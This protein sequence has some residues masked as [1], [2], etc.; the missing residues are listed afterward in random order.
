ME[1]YNCAERRAFPSTAPDSD[2]AWAFVRYSLRVAHAILLPTHAT[3]GPQGALDF[4]LDDAHVHGNGA[5]G[6]QL[7]YPAKRHYPV[8][9]DDSGKEPERVAWRLKER[10]RTVSV[11]L[12][13]CLNIRVDPPDVIK[14]SPCVPCPGARPRLRVLEGAD[15]GGAGR[16]ARLECWTDPYSMSA[17]KVPPPPSTLL[18]RTLPHRTDAGSGRTR[19]P[20]SARTRVLP[21]R[22]A[23]PA[24]RARAGTDA[25]APPRPW[26]G[27]GDYRQGARTAVPALAGKSR[28]GPVIPEAGP[29]S[30]AP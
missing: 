30:A 26:A 29:L 21:R 25:P 7:L 18:R 20:A 19:H 27:A 14:P 17:P 1:A 2:C 4:T 16:C 3:R 24:A 15:A 11:A 8:N 10:M 12:V 23:R 6:E 22:K 9:P 28:G 5:E 13:A